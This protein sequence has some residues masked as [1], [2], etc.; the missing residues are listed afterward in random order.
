MAGILETI[1]A[2]ADAVTATAGLG[3]KLIPPDEN[4]IQAFKARFPNIYRRSKMH[5][6]RACFRYL[7]HHREVTVEEFV[8]FVGGTTITAED[9][10]ALADMLTAE[11][12]Q[13]KK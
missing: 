3:T 2:V 8:K 1:Q 4:R 10:K 13:T 5:M 7:R 6:L 12:N 11:L 9:E